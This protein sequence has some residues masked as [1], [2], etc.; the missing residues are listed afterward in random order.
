MASTFL[1]PIPPDAKDLASEFLARKSW[2][3]GLI[4]A[5]VANWD[6]YAHRFMILDDSG[7]MGRVDGKTLME[8]KGMQKE[9]DCSR[10]TEMARSVEFHAELADIAKAPTEF[11]LLNASAPI[12]I[13]EIEDDG[14]ARARLQK[15]LEGSPSGG[16]PLCKVVDKVVDK[17]KNMEPELR[18]RGQQCVI[19]IYSDGRAQDGD[20]SNVLKKLI[21]LPVWV[22]IRLCTSEDDITDYWSNIDN[23]IELSMDVLDDLTGEALEVNRCNPWLTYGE[24]L[25]RLRESG[26]HIREFDKLDEG[27]LAPSELHSAIP[28]VIGGKKDDFVHPDLDLAGFKTS[29]QAAMNKVGDIWDPVTK[30]MQPWIK[31]NKLGGGGCCTI[32]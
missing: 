24:P 13:G 26:C 15:I 4:K 23:N 2:P 29:V 28:I 32:A 21:S 3:P 6:R 14:A 27:R 20:I 7:S 19:T 5:M 9:I 31:V 12:T 1:P 10:W 25:H 30:R 8:S 16:T 17:I 18:Q 22:V 11:C